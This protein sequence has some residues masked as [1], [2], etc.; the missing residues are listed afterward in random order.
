MSASAPGVAMPPLPPDLRAAL[1]D[2]LGDMLLA[3]LREYP[4]YPGT[5]TR[6]VATGSSPTGRARS[7]P[8]AS[9]QMPLP[10]SA[11]AAVAA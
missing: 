4:N 6:D 1:V 7:V 3:D 11:Y 10:L 9:K 8:S 2:I 5:L